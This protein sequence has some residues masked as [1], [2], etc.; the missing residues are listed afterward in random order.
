MNEFSL[1]S[2]KYNQV[3]VIDDSAS[4]AGVAFI[5]FSISIFLMNKYANA[6][7]FWIY[8]VLTN[9]DIHDI[10][11][12]IDDGVKSHSIGCILMLQRNDEKRFDFEKHK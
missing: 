7:H 4:L 2:G 3:I 1:G 6:L 8:I 5:F 12:I 9:R 10:I 11:I